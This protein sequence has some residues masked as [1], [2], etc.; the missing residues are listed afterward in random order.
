MVAT[1]Q[2]YLLEYHTTPHDSH[3]FNYSLVSIVT[4]RDAIYQIWH[5][6]LLA[7]MPWTEADNLL[8]QWTSGISGHGLNLIIAEYSSMNPSKFHIS[9]SS[10]I[11][12]TIILLV[13]T[14]FYISIETQ[15]GRFGIVLV[16]NARRQWF[17][18]TQNQLLHFKVANRQ[19]LFI[20]YLLGHQLRVPKHSNWLFGVVISIYPS[21][22]SYIKNILLEYKLCR[23][24]Q[25]MYM[26]DIFL[27]N[28]PHNMKYD[29]E[30]TLW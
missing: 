1:S 19:Y 6:T 5:K 10:I 14:F 3:M 26:P 23:K 28:V 8:T 30:I 12:S 27:F 7:I 17:L 15:P 24:S 22:F 21:Y 2:W 16:T 4:E 9:S 25:Y 11:S 29:D 13:A 20:N 18:G